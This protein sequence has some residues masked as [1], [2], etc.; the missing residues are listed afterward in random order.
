MDLY[1]L[2]ILHLGHSME[3][4]YLFIRMGQGFK[5]PS[6]ITL[7]NK[8]HILQR[9]FGIKARL[10]IICLMAKA[11]KLIKKM[12]MIFKALINKDI[13]YK[14]FSNG[15]KIMFNTLTKDS[16]LQVEFF[17][18]K[19]MSRLLRKITLIAFRNIYRRVQR[20]FKTWG[21]RLLI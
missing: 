6:L 18:A 13:K 19:V 21:R 14:V 17:P 11:S 3:K 9:N 16:F 12:H 15:L 7:F 5:A 1:I 2:D 8:E 4:G 10:K 20:Q